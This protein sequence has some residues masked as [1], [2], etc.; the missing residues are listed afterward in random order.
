MCVVVAG[1]VA[2]CMVEDVRFGVRDCVAH[3]VCGFVVLSVS[4]FVEHAGAFFNTLYLGLYLICL[5]CIQYLCMSVYVP[6]SSMLG[7]LL[8]YLAIAIGAGNK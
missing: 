1:C 5:G 4:T 2:M 6:R 8:R 7:I 3:L